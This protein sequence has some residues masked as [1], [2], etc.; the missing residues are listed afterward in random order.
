MI[1]HHFSKRF[2]KDTDLQFKNEE[3]EKFIAGYMVGFLQCYP[4]LIEV[5]DI[6]HMPG[7]EMWIFKIAVN[8]P[9]SDEPLIDSVDPLHIK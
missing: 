6:P 7:E 1:D 9:K 4:H 2:K 5:V 3:F 8:E